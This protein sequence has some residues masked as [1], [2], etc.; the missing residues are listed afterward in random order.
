M[1]CS[2]CLDMSHETIREHHYCFCYYGY[3]P[4]SPTT[5]SVL[6]KTAREAYVT[7]LGTNITTGDNQLSWW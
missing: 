2:P 4:P 1:H 7:E 5:T 6:N 3:P